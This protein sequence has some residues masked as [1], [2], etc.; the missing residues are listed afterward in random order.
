MRDMLPDLGVTVTPTGHAD[1][2]LETGPGKMRTQRLVKAD[3]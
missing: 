3:D 1:L 2:T